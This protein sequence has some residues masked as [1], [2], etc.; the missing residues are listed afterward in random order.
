MNTVP[1]DIQREDEVEVLQEEHVLGCVDVTGHVI[2][3]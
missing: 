2:Q 1:E 3:V